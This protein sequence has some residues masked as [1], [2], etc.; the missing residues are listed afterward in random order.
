MKMASVA[1]RRAVTADADKL[2]EV[3]SAAYGALTE[4]WVSLTDWPKRFQEP[5]AFTY[6]AEDES[7][8][9]Y[10]SSGD[11]GE[12]YFR[13]GETGEIMGLALRP[14]YWGFGYG[15][16]LLVHGLSVLKRRG[17]EHAI[18][19][20]PA[21]SPVAIGLS[22]K[23]K[24]SRLESSRVSNFGEVEITEFCYKLALGRYF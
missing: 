15:Q 9:G 6:L 16:K 23:L 11:P 8:F 21:L 10:V 7:P 17:F 4:N 20:I 5:G 18:I 1:I 22:E 24:F 2:A 3:Q 19:W 12:D 13:D 14:D